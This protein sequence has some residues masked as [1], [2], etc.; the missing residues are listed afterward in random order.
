MWALESYGQ[1]NATKP[2]P[3]RQRIQPSGNAK[4]RLLVPY[5]VLC[6]Y[7]LT[8]QDR[9]CRLHPPARRGAHSGGRTGQSGQK[10]LGA[11]PAARA[12][13]TNQVA[14]ANVSRCAARTPVSWGL[15]C[16]VLRAAPRSFVTCPTPETKT[17]RQHIQWGRPSCR[18]IPFFG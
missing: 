2:Q 18:P 6:W 17:A 3:E 5:E 14:D 7:H 16:V 1:R 8:D 13:P 4:H 12:T 15:S 9:C 10:K 11:L